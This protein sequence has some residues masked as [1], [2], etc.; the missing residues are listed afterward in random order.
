MLQYMA[1][2]E[3]TTMSAV[4]MRELEDLASA[5]ADELSRSIPGFAAAL[6]WP[7]VDPAHHVC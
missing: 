1:E 7:F 2:Q 6:A 3:S 4:L 5:H